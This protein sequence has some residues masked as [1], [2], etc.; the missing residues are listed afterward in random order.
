[1]GTGGFRPSKCM[2]KVSVY[3]TYS[4]RM[5]FT[6]KP[7]TLVL[8]ELVS[9][10]LFA[11]L[12]GSLSASVCVCLS[13]YVHICMS[14]VCLYSTI[15]WSFVVEAISFLKPS[16]AVGQ[17]ICWYSGPLIRLYAWSACRGEILT[18]STPC[19]SLLNMHHTLFTYQVSNAGLESWAHSNPGDVAIAAWNWTDWAPLCR[20][21]REW[22]AMELLLTQPFWCVCCTELLTSSLVCGSPRSR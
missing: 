1:M 3:W 22:M 6:C 20:E 2:E 17:F 18:L 4:R 5:K 16:A 13:V 19:S 11:F 7:I 12:G 8:F 10:S 14:W 9:L 15:V 21:R